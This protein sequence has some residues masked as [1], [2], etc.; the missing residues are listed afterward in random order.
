MCTKSLL[1]LDVQ[2]AAVSCMFG[3][4][5]VQWGIIKLPAGLAPP[6][7]NIDSASVVCQ[8]RS[9]CRE[10]ERTSMDINWRVC[11]LAPAA[12]C[13]QRQGWVWGIGD[14]WGKQ[15][16]SYLHGIH[17]GAKKFPKESLELKRIIWEGCFFIRGVRWGFLKQKFLFELYG[18]P[19]GS[20][21]ISAIGWIE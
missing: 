15:S 5:P 4:S 13:V 14:G 8:G 20:R 1:L 11:F 10:R 18:N 7:S 12:G 3:L 6:S 2:Q 17:G 16:G 9:P 19:E 21:E